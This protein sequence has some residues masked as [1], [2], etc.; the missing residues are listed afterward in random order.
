M[1]QTNKESL[2][3]SDFDYQL[4][5]EFIASYPLDN[6]SDSRLL[7]VDNS[8]GV[9]N[10]SHKQFRD[11]VDL[12]QPDDLLVL[13]NTK[14]ISARL[15]GQKASGGKV[16]VLVERVLGNS[17]VLAH[18]KASRS[19]KAGQQLILESA[20]SAVMIERQEALFIL[21]FDVPENDSI[22]NLLEQYGHMPLPHYME[23]DDEQLDKERYQTV[24]A[25]KQGAVAAPTASLHFDEILL[26]R[27]AA[28]GVNTAKVT[29]HVGAGTFQPVR[30]EEI[31]NH[32]MH[33]EWIDVPQETVDAIKQCRENGGRVVAI[34]TTVVRSLETAAKAT[35]EI[36]PYQGDTD[37]FIFPGY[38]FNVIDALVTNFHLPQ[39]TLLMLVSA[40]VGRDTIMNAYHEAIDHKYRFFSYG[41]AMFLLP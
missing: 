28:K 23:R 5:Q 19:P 32:V 39:S 35:G 31:D 29:L 8:D 12:L 33:K 27:I 16:E 6:R 24:F 22:F 17:C 26:E 7:C 1:N 9:G 30:S 21:Q 40:F 11:I 41:D 34:G 15:Y 13:N 25:E 3:T 18:V 20:I 37:I 36:A 14:V 10:F 2:K 4:P 38:Q